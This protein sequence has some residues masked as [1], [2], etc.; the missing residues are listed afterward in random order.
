MTRWLSA[1]T[2]IELLVVVAIIAILAAMLLPALA[3]ARE[4][5]RRSTCMSNLKQMGTALESY[6]GEYSGY[7]PCWPGWFGPNVDWCSPNKDACTLPIYDVVFH[8]DTAGFNG[9]PTEFCLMKYSRR[10]PAGTIET[11]DIARR[12]SPIHH[13]YRAIG[14]LYKAGTPFRAGTLTGA[15]TGLGNLLVTGFITDGTLFYCNSAAEMRGDTWNPITYPTGNQ[16]AGACNLSHWKQA[17]GFD[18]NAFLFGDWSGCELQGGTA[19][20]VIFST[21]NYRNI[22]VNIYNAWHAGVERTP[23]ARL[24]LPGVRPNAY[25]KVGGPFFRTGK[26]LGNR[27]VVCDTFS[28]GTACDAEGRSATQ[29]GTDI[30]A[31]AQRASY[32]LKHHRDG[33]NVLYGDWHAAWYG[34]P[35]G[36]IVWMPEAARDNVAANDASGYKRLAMNAWLTTDYYNGFYQTMEDMRNKYT[37]VAVW[38]ELD[39]AGGVDVGVQ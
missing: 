20:N 35:Q 33:F 13:S 8:Q 19:A 15:P 30:P 1:F 29:F 26:E 37:S 28:K 2:L 21:Y 22:P 10:T 11:Y 18:Q 24:R 32:A 6:S 7:M 3:A 23:N 9:R 14:Y 39:S 36:R 16:Q 34:D 38:H 5:A 27:S 31:S 4:K 25:V 17:G 12:Y